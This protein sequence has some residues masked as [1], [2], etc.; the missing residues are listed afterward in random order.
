MKFNFV[1]PSSVVRSIEDGVQ[2]TG[3]LLSR[4]GAA[5]LVVLG[6]KMRLARIEYNAR[7]LADAHVLADRVTREQQDVDEINARLTELLAM[8]KAKL[9]AKAKP[10]ARKRKAA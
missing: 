1:R 5:A 2:G 7:R 8:R 6:D 9:K 3:Q 10:A 4:V